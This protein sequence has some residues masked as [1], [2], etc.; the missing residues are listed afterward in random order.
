MSYRKL[1]WGMILILMGILFIFKNLGFIWFS[2]GDIWQ[3]WPVL[4][5]VWGV[6]MLPIKSVYRLLFSLAA[7]VFGIIL[8]NQ[9]GTKTDILRWGNHGRNF[10]YHNNQIYDNDDDDEYQN[11]D[12]WNAMESGVLFHTMD[13]NI[14]LA[15]LNMEVGAGNFDVMGTTSKLIDCQLEHKDLYRLKSRTTN[16][17]AIIDFTMK[18]T[19][20]NG[21]KISNNVD[22]KLNSE[23]EWIFDLD[24][25]AAEM[26]MDLRPFNVKKIKLDGG[27]SS[28]TFTLG[29]RA[30]KTDIE[31]DAG[32]A[33]ITLH[34]PKEAG[35]EVHSESFMIDRSLEGLEKISNGYYRTSNFKKADQ[36][37][38]IDLEA[39][40]SSFTI[41]RY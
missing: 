36:I 27:A 15:E 7:I 8:V 20:W 38:S 23:P 28:I 1:F 26:E 11:D 5:I 17:K 12:D 31:I 21:K 3:F 19:H 2:W 13:N 37:I 40:I 30:K 9:Y 39:A 35:C 34:I 22:I 6:S 32:A 18:D 14:E 41:D 29:D 24:V 4:L 10:S 16:D 33:S 25:G